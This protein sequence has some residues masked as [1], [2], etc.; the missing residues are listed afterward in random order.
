M[1]SAGVLSWTGNNPYDWVTDR[2]A[3][4]GDDYLNSQRVFD[5]MKADGVTHVLDCRIEAC[6]DDRRFSPKVAAAHKGAFVYLNN[7]CDDDFEPKSVD[8]FRRSLDFGLDALRD[9]E[10]K[11]YVHCA[12]GYNRGPSSAYAILRATGLRPAE[13]EVA[14]AASRTVGLA[15]LGCAE[16]AVRELGMVPEIASAYVYCPPA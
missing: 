3:V 15:Y 10:A 2:V 5:E 6:D 11:L 9:P 7:G 4:G 12:A 8:Y 16:R 1:S 13:A 14:I